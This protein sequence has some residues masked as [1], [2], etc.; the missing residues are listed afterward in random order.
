MLRLREV[1]AFVLTLSAVLMLGSALSA[2]ASASPVWRFNGSEFTGKK[3]TIVG[4]ATLSSLAIPSLT[5]TCKKMHY[6]MTISNSAGTGK[7][8]LNSLSFT[9]C[10][11]SNPECTVKT[12][13]AEKLPWA[14]HLA[15]VASS[16]YLVFEGVKIGIV[17]GGA[18][19]ALG[20]T[21]VT[22]TGSAGALYDNTSETFAFSP[23]SFKATATA[24]KAFG[25]PIEWQGVFTTEATGPHNGEAL[26]A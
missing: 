11:T 9:T 14:A 1:R 24:L 20:E 17:Y 19:C 2:G 12:I 8:E 3:E 21:L 7:A 5:T 13:G 16:P 4:D 22:V 26:T 23:S 18:T 6:E 15:T 25:S 10:F